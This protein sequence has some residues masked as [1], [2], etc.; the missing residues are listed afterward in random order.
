MIDD[1]L[2]HITHVVRGCEYLTSTPKY[3][4]L[5]EAFGWEVP[6]Y[7]HLPLI[8]GKNEDGSVSKL[9]SVMARPDFADLVREGYLPET[10]VN[11]IALLGWC[12]KENR[13]LFTLDELA[14]NFSIDGISKSPAVFD[15]DKL[16][17]FNAEYIRSMEPEKFLSLAMP[18]F[19]EVFGEKECDWQVLASILQPRVIQM[20]QIPEMISFFRELPDYPVDFFVNKKSKTNLENSGTMLEAAIAELEQINDWKLDVLHEALISLA[21]RLG[22]KNGTLLWPVRIAAAGVQVTP[23]GAMEILTILGKD[24]AL[25]RLRIGLE[26]LK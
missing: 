5:Y 14:Q 10:I 15:Y 8:M 17:W 25:R 9:S 11:Y 3:N 6:T 18:Y 23:G 24:E 22:V 26:K 21:G 13:E 20:T 12:P 2:M 19:R 1:H 7:V 16:K 4:L